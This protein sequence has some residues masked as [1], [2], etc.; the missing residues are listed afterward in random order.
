MQL[1]PYQLQAID[2]ARRLFAG[3]KRI[4]LAQPTGAGKTVMGAEIARR[5]AA[6]GKSVTFVCDQINLV[7]QTSDRFREW[8]I[9]HG[10][11][12]ADNDRD[13]DR[14]VMIA[15]AQSI[16]TRM[17]KQ[18][19]IPPG[20]VVLDECHIQRDILLKRL[21]EADSHVLGPDSDSL[22][23]RHGRVLPSHD[24]PADAMVLRP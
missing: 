23:R 6:R 3:R 22:R 10:V 18:G 20:L 24:L 16:E 4:V 21:K 12:Q 15:S 2:D 9:E 19:W 17:E 8:G 14:Q 7:Y 1:R 5:A 13:T 11:I